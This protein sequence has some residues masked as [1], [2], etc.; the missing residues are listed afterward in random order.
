MFIKVTYNNDIMYINVAHIEMF[1]HRVDHTQIDYTH[2]W[3]SD[4]GYVAVNESM[5]EILKL[6]EEARK[7]GN[8]G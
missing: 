6:I 2:I 7:R 3:L 5:D 8:Q 1:K 4:D